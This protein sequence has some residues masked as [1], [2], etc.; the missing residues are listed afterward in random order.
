MTCTLAPARFAWHLTPPARDPHPRWP[1]SSHGERPLIAERA[2][3]TDIDAM[4]RLEDTDR[5][6]VLTEISRETDKWLWFVEA[7][8]QGTDRGPG[9]GEK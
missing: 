8:R 2:V 9:G 6:D 4:E 3:R 7:R 1:A 5:A